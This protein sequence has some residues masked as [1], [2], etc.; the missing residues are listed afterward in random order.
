MTILDCIPEQG[1][2]ETAL[3]VATGL[4]LSELR[5]QLNI[6]I[7]KRKIEPVPDM[8]YHYR[9]VMVRVPKPQQILNLLAHQK[10]E[11]MEIAIELDC[12]SI[13]TKAILKQMALKGEIIQK[14]DYWELNSGNDDVSDGIDIDFEEISFDGDERINSDEL[15][16]TVLV[17]A[18]QQ[19]IGSGIEGLTYDEMQRRHHLERKVERSF[20]EAGTALKELR[21]SRL[22]R[23]RWHNWNDYVAD[24]FGWKANYAYKQIAAAEVVQGL[25][26][27]YEELC[28]T[29]TESVTLTGTLPT[30]E[31]QVRPLTS[32]DP[33]DRATVW[34]T[35][36]DKAN[37]KVPT[38]ALVK[39]AVKEFKSRDAVVNP[40]R[41]LQVVSVKGKSGWFVVS[42]VGEFSCTCHD[43]TGKETIA[44]FFDLKEITLPPEHRQF[45][46]ELQARLAD[47]WQMADQLISDNDCNTV[48]ALVQA[49]GLNAIGFLTDFQEQLLQLAELQLQAQGNL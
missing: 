6:L 47:L 38:E 46:V 33:E 7:R 25:I 40:F 34:K 48:K 44:R 24:R 39:E 14:G 4:N 41:L 43:F 31:K 19:S 37:G 3:A 2:G 29:G 5:S 23:D 30:S 35:A 28:T 13:Q 12:D 11:A 21:D 20:Y 27:S 22:Y 17:E 9:P 16:R 26:E 1:I 15:P 10:L 45:A 18:G 32:L 8:P 36:V 42:Y 49:V